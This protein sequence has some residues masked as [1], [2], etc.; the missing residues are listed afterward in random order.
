MIYFILADIHAN[1]LAL[2]AVIQDSRKVLNLR[3]DQ[4]HKYIFLGDIVGRGPLPI[5]VFTKL[6]SVDPAIWLAGNHDKAI[7]SDQFKTKM[8]SPDREILEIHRK[9]L[10]D[11][12]RERISGYKTKAILGD[13]V[14][15]HGFPLLDEDRSVEAYEKDYISDPKFIEDLWQTEYEGSHIW[16]MGHSHRQTFWQYSQNTK[17]WRIRS[18]RSNDSNSEFGQSLM[19]DNGHFQL[20]EELNGRYSIK[21]RLERSEISE[22]LLIINPGSIG[23][24]RDGKPPILSPALSL[25]KYLIMEEADG[26][27]IFHYVAV[28]YKNELLLQTWRNSNYPNEIIR[29]FMI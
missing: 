14:L 22:S 9:V 6:D 27:I 17:Q 1:D 29:R 4:S 5:Q 21:F 18:L 11:G 28:S 10:N 3:D 19:G 12:L 25:A 2:D 7:I 24:P 16:I 20:S 8:H 15:S 13:M 23:F 26:F